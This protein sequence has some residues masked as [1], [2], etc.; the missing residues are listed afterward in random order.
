MRVRVEPYLSKRLGRARISIIS[1]IAATAALGLTFGA[2]EAPAGAESGAPWA[3]NAGSVAE[4]CAALG[5]NGGDNFENLQGATT[6]ITSAKITTTGS[7]AQ[8]ATQCTV[9][10]YVTPSDTFVV[11]LPVA[12]W[13]GKLEANGSHGL[14]GAY[15]LNE[16]APFLG[17]G[18]A[19][20]ANSLGHV[21]PGLNGGFAYGNPQAEIDFAY[22]ATH[23]TTVAA[24][25]I[26][27][28]FYGVEPRESYFSGCSEGGRQGLVE[29]E[30]YPADF[31]GIIA[32]PAFPYWSTIIGYGSLYTDVVNRDR[33]GRVILTTDKLPIL[34]K[35]AL[36]ACGG[37][38]GTIADPEGC[39]FD[40]VAAQCHETN[41]HGADCL[42]SAQ[43]AVARLFYGPIRNSRGQAITA[44]GSNEPGSEL[45]W[46]S[47]IND[48]GGLS[49]EGGIGIQFDRYMAFPSDPGPAFQES[50]FNFDTDPAR[51]NNLASIYDASPD[52]RAFRND[53]GKLIMWS[54]WA[55]QAMP[56]AATVQFYKAI[57]ANDGGT[58][59]AQSSVRLFMI[60]GEYHCE[61]GTGPQLVSA[62]FAD[63]L[64]SWVTTGKAP[65]TA[66]AVA[67]NAAGQV[68]AT[69]AI[70]AYPARPGLQQ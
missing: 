12:G 9:D 55:D 67:T 42:S 33:A 24:K 41:L 69:R 15:Y 50:D 43:V 28:A 66:T 57:V 2:V 30:R 23:V 29:A 39:H 8:A 18:Y 34:H 37:V 14:G 35:A 60:P 64:D 5:A 32:G 11:Q 1:G 22:R 27:T 17:K 10:G 54:G 20:V 62:S 7:G 68:T 65:Q 38:D 58:A 19:T 16:C 4:K 45:A 36:Q 59:S 44:Y 46:T 3:L 52:L 21:D 47:R 53:G 26:L 61:G 56:P 40:P 49:L 51:L 6:F 63:L 70:N 48:N 13:N 25:A 31:N